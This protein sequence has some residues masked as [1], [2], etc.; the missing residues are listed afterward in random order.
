M[1]RLVEVSRE[2]AAQEALERQ[3]RVRYDRIKTHLQA[4]VGMTQTA[5]Q[6]QYGEP[7]L[8]VLTR[9]G[10]RLLIYRE[11]FSWCS[12]KIYLYCSSLDT[13]TKYEIVQPCKKK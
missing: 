4:V 10:N 9:E 2:K 13:I 7:S 6:K 5:V 8:T 3:A 11:S 1:N 12:E